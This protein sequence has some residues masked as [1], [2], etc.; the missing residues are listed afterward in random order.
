VAHR[1]PLLEAALGGASID[2]RLG[3]LVEQEQLGPL[4][5][6]DDVRASA[7]YRLDATVTVLRRLLAGFAP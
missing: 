4:A 5:P 2:R 1:L 3:N 7:A 6:I